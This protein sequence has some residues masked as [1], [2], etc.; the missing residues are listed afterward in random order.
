M[1]AMKNKPIQSTASPIKEFFKAVFAFYT[2]PF[3]GKKILHKEQLDLSEYNLQK[4][5]FTV[6]RDAGKPVNLNN[7]NVAQGRLRLKLLFENELLGR[8]FNDQGDNLLQISTYK[9]DK[10]LYTDEIIKD[11]VEISK[12]IE[13]NIIYKK[14]SSE[15]ESLSNAFANEAGSKGE[16]RFLHTSGQSADDVPLPN[17]ISSSN[18]YSEELYQKHD[19]DE[20]RLLEHK[21]AFHYNI[22]MMKD[23]EIKSRILQRKE[24]FNNIWTQLKS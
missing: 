15:T 14:E 11:I 1:D 12:K 19:E 22:Q 4:L 3:G 24:Q 18:A 21:A 10:D 9:L 23:E 8:Y 6:L 5:Y 13:V 7:D 16:L 17:F 20:K 2:L